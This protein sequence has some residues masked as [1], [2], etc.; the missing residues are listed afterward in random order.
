MSLASGSTSDL[1]SGIS[2]NQRPDPKQEAVLATLCHRQSNQIEHKYQ[3]WCQYYEP[4]LTVLY[5][6]VKSK[7]ESNRKLFRQTSRRLIEF[8][9]FCWWV[10]RN[11]LSQINPRSGQRERP[12]LDRSILDPPILDRSILDPPILDRSI[13]D[14]P[15]LD[16]SDELSP[17]NSETTEGT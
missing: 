10:Y 7:L 14:P 15:I 16:R 1:G 8:N 17:P 11:T 12:L 3:V 4:E 2:F 6:R 13:L 9:D 5:Q